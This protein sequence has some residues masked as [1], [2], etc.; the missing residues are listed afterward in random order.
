MREDQQTVRVFRHGGGGSLTASICSEMANASRRRHL[1]ENAK[2]VE[3]IAVELGYSSG[4]AFSRG[5]KRTRGPLQAQAPPFQG[6]L[7]FSLLFPLRP[8]PGGC[9]PRPRLERAFRAASVARQTR[10]NPVWHA[11]RFHSRPTTL[12]PGSVR[13]LSPFPVCL[14][15]LPLW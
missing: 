3:E 14:V 1:K 6:S 2:N 9:R 10:P 7:D 11:P 15:P 5:F 12:P 8:R 13:S 4:A